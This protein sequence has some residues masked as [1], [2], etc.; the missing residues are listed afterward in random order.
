M[1]HP[2]DDRLLDW[3][4]DGTALLFWSDREGSPGVWLQ[5]MQ[6]GKPSGSAERL[7]DLEGGRPGARLRE[8]WDLL[9]RRG[10]GPPA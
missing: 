6:S 10:R 5:P 8:R 3:T 2:A 7:T 9:H 4:P 1:Q